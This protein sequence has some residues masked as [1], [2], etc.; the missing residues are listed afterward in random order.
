[1]HSALLLV[2]VVAAA[3]FDFT[4]GFHDTANVVA[5]SISTRALAPRTAI[6]LVSVLNFAGAFISL[7]VAATIATGIIDAGQVTETIAFACLVGAIAWNLITWAYGLPSSSSHALIGGVIGAML[8]AVGGGGIKFGGLLAKVVLPALVAPASAFVIAGLVIAFIY[9]VFGRRSPGPVTR[10]FR[11]GQIVSN[12]APAL[13]HRTNDAQKTMGVITLALVA[14]GSL[15]PHHA[16]VPAWVVILS[17][18]AISLRTYAGGWRIIRTVG[19]R[20]IRMD[21]AQAFSAQASGAAVIPR[22][23]APGIPTLLDPRHLRRGHGGRGGHAGVGGALGR[24]WHDRRRV[25]DHAADGRPVRGRRLRRGLRLRPRRARPAA[26]RGGR[27]AVDDARD[28][29][30]SWTR[31]RPPRERLTGGLGPD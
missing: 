11:V 28:P 9:R 16:S 12:S 6:T 19:S 3:A 20:I 2:I 29:A 31:P 7:K 17:A 26:H 4:N 24:G 1:V 8:A 23:L 10:G 14:H 25:G 30:S 22:L 18:T 27:A 21:S 15:S 5:S 13:A